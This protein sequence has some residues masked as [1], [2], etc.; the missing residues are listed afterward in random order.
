MDLNSTC[1]TAAGLWAGNKRYTFV[2]ARVGPAVVCGS[3]SRHLVRYGHEY[4]FSTLLGRHALTSPEG[5]GPCLLS[6]FDYR[7]VGHLAF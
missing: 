6:T 2:T 5:G 4:Y 7:V 1:V 3:S